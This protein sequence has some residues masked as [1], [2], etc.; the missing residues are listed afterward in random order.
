MTCKPDQIRIRVG[1]VVVQDGAL[2]LVE[3]RKGDRRYWVYPG[4]GLDYGET[5]AACGERELREETGLDVEIG[6]LLFVSESIPPDGH[7]HVV[8][9]FVAARVVGGTLALGQEENL[10]SV[11]FVPL[12]E[13]AT[14]E[15]YPPV[16]PEVLRAV[17]GDPDPPLLLG[18]RWG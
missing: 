15:I 7:R 10:C 6:P 16:L 13:L 12:E 17:R 5:I 11:R 14:L 18:N 4:G 9:L 8:N 3:H 1:V 2:L